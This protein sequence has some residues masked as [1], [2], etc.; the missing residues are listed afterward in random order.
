MFHSDLQTKIV[1]LPES[2][3]RVKTAILLCQSGELHCRRPECKVVL[4][5]DSTQECPCLRVLLRSA[6]WYLG[7]SSAAGD[8]SEPQQ[9]QRNKFSGIPD[10]KRLPINKCIALTKIFCE[11]FTVRTRRTDTTFATSSFSVSRILL[12][13]PEGP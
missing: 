12:A 3:S 11:L 9:Q 2:F 13:N 6:A 5:E 7:A 8:R 10:Q 1:K 4:E